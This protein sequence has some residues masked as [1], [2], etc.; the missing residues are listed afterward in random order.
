EIEADG[1]CFDCPDRSK[2]ATLSPSALDETDCLSLI[3]YDD[4]IQS[5]PTGTRE[6]TITVFVTE[7]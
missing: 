1:V 6:C 7:N 2:L 4:L 5:V 3:S